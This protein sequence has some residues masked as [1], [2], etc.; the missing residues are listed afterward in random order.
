MT[1]LLLVLALAVQDTVVLKPVVVTA[2]R[3]PVPADAVTAAVTVIKGETLRERGIRTVAEAL[4]ETL[5]ASVVESNGAGS[6]T[7]LFLRGGESDYVKVLLDGVPLNQPGG[8]YTFAHLTTDDVE[9]IEI[10]RGPVSVLYGSDA[11]AGVVQIFTRTGFGGGGAVPRVDVDAGAGSYGES[12]FGGTVT[13]G[14]ARL[15]YSLGASRFASDGVYPVNNSYRNEVVTARLRWE[16][17][18]RTDA[19][20]TARH[21]DGVFH[22]PT[23]GAGQVVDANQFATDRG[24]TVSVELGRH[25]TSRLE[26]R[27]LLGT[28]E[29]DGR[30]DDDPDAPGD[31]TLIFHSRDRVR[32]RG[33]EVRVNWQA[34]PSAL[35]TGGVALEDA[36]LDHT[37]AC[38]FY[39][40]GSFF[41]CSGAPMNRTR[42]TRAVFAEWLGGS[43]G[44]RAVSG[45]VGVR[46]E[47]NE[48][49]GTFATWR[50]GVAWRL[51][52]ATRLRAA[53]GTG[54]KEPTFLEAYSTGFV[55]GNPDLKPERSFSW[56]GGIEHTV[57]GTSLSIAV[58]YFNQRFADLVV[59][60]FSRTPNYVN[61]AA[62]R[63]S[64]AEIQLDCVLWRGVLASVA[65]TYLD[66]RV[67]DG[68]GD[69]TFETGK[70]L[71]R[72]PTNAAS[73]RFTAGLGP[74]GTATVGARFVGDRDDLDFSGF[75]AA[76]VTLHPYTRVQAGVEYTVLRGGSWGDVTLRAQGEN[77]LADKGRE[78]ANYPVRG[79]TLFF[80]MT[81]GAGSQ[82]SK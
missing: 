18:A 20:V 69:P 67:L 28:S 60:D 14:T 57:P 3:V 10:V 54:F 72:R 66:T 58:T 56:E 80:G 6:Q 17:D 62:A 9:R 23:N 51:D 37:D 22:Y 50:A 34:S 76:R 27:V 74:R 65:Y 13:G 71:I 39:S 4:R 38:Q 12:R 1:A 64:G 70:R 2:T 36:R 15:A 49:F 31:T 82:S 52:A 24:P 19:S 42:S 68:G 21:G 75:P 7:S 8:A 16:P 44:G 29:T 46:L 73:V 45:N 35:I 53:A 30:L 47:D 48:Q 63:S 78:I 26:T 77:L 41:D 32:R 33:G 81:L 5:G 79:R 11:V 61:I 43:G 59:Y 40:A 55:V 25:V